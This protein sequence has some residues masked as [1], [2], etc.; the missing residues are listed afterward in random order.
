MLYIVIYIYNNT[1]E[2]SI[3]KLKNVRNVDLTGG[4]CATILCL[5]IAKIRTDMEIN[6]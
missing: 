2:M 6:I 1:L 3:E 5:C 4:K